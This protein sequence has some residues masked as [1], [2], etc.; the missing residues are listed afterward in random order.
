MDENIKEVIVDTGDECK[1]QGFYWSF[2]CGHVR[3]LEYFK[4]DVF[5]VCAACSQPIKWLLQ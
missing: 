5:P 2:G 1:I 3:V 4:Q